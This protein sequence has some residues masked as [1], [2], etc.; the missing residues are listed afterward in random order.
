MTCFILFHIL[1]M[2]DDLQE[3]QST[4]SPVFKKS[5]RTHVCVSSLDSLQ[6]SVVQVLHMCMLRNRY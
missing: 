4:K 1:G 5:R 6:P 2:N 3:D